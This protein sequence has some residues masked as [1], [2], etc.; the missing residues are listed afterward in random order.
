MDM[1]W[2]GA[3]EPSSIDRGLSWASKNRLLRPRLQLH[4]KRQILKTV[5]SGIDMFSQSTN[6][7]GKRQL[8]KAWGLREGT[9]KEIGRKG[10]GGRGWGFGKTI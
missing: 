5:P 10:M 4:Y 2:V 7:A 8:G 9:V 3:C 1:G 6:L